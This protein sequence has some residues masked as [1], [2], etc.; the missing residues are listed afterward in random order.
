ML[1]ITVDNVSELQNTRQERIIPCAWNS[2]ECQK[3]YFTNLTVYQ[4]P[5]RFTK[6]CKYGS[7]IFTQKFGEDTISDIS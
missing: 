7:Q 3:P 6:N 5:A 4:I 1:W 2:N